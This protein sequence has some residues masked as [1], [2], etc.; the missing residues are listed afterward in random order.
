LLEAARAVLV[1][2]APTAATLSPALSDRCCLMV[3]V[4]W[5]APGSGTALAVLTEAAV[6]AEPAEMLA[7]QQTETRPT[8]AVAATRR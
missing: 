8:A 1:D 7:A 3:A 2:L 5:L 4:V 6:E